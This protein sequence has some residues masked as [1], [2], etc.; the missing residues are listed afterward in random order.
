MASNVDSVTRNIGKCQWKAG[1]VTG[2]C[3]AVMRRFDAQN[4]VWCLQGGKY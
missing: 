4:D 2:H 3:V 1:V